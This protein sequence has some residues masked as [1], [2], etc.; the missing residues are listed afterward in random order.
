MGRQDEGAGPTGSANRQKDEPTNKAAAGAVHGLK[1][2]QGTGS[3]CWCAARLRHRWAGFALWVSG[4]GHSI[5]GNRAGSY[6][7]AQRVGLGPSEWPRECGCSDPTGTSSSGEG[8]AL[9]ILPQKC[10]AWGDADG[11]RR[12]QKRQRGGQGQGQGQGWRLGVGA[13]AGVGAGGWAL[14]AMQ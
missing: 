14:E 4:G 8:A 13:G 12:H 2:G 3:R 5:T 6:S 1:Q 11:P 10:L 9:T 7:V